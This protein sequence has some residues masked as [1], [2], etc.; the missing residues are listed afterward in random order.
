MDKI[1]ARSLSVSHSVC[2]S[3][4]LSVI[5]SVCLSVILSVVWYIFF[6]ADGRRNDDLRETQQKVHR[7][8][9]ERN[10]SFKTN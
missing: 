8:P 10:A 3:V 5:L 4:I 2:M 9:N 7:V 6:V 1:D